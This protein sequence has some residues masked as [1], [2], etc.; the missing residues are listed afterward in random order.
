MP[1]QYAKTFLAIPAQIENQKYYD[2]RTIDDKVVY[3]LKKLAQAN[4]LTLHQ[5]LRRNTITMDQVSHLVV[6]MMAT[7]QQ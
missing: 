6:I 5:N 2:R 1:C 4:P 7:I 3:E